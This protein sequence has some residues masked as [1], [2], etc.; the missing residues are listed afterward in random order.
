MKKRKFADGGEAEAMAQM[1]RDKAIASGAA[2]PPTPIEAPPTPIEAPPTPTKAIPAP[3]VASDG[4]PPGAIP[5][6]EGAFSTPTPQ[7]PV[8]YRDTEKDIGIRRAAPPVRS[9]IDRRRRPPMQERAKGGSIK[10]YAK[11]GSV[12][13]ASS[14]GDGCAQ[15]GKTKGRF[16]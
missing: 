12:S 14:R 13:S 4:M 16:V 11:G 1:Q 2:A 15:R 7:P 3:K 6:P 5:A 9:E 10:G 8:M